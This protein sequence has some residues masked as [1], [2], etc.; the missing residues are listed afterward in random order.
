MN[1]L[2]AQEDVVQL[3]RSGKRLLLAGDHSLLSS[4]PK[5]SWI[6]GTSPYFMDENGGVFSQ[7]KIFV[8]ELPECVQAI[9]IT[10]YSI[11]NIEKVYLDAPDNGFSVIILPAFSPIH[12]HFSTNAPN[13]TDFAAKTLVGWV[14]GLNLNHPHAPSPQIFN[15]TNSKASETTA[16]VLHA[17][18]P[19][20]KIADLNII[21]IFAQGTGDS[22]YFPEE[23]FR[24]K[25]ALING[26]EVDFAQYILDKKIDAQ[27]PLVADMCGAMINTSFKTI[28]TEENQLD[29]YAPVFTNVEY[30]IATPLQNYQEQFI[31]MIPENSAQSVFFSCNCILNYLYA[32]LEGKKTAHYRGPIT[33]GEIAYQLLNQTLVY[34]QIEDI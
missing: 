15:G 21:N 20:N 30:K 5:G 9:S 33:F 3:I 13:F 11:E 18:L 6:A 27:L 14:S 8:T 22:I 2:L 26:T 7:D 25:R 23:G 34:L 12:S 1:R 31:Q 19:K 4:L 24:A 16:V 10:E 32:D 29:F 28:N 17:S